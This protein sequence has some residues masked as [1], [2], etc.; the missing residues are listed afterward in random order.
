M[1]G[2]K[3]HCTLMGCY[4]TTGTFIPPFFIYQGKRI[5]QGIIDEAP[6][7]SVVGVSESGW[8][9]EDLF[10]KWLGHFNDSIPPARPALLIVDNH[11]SRF[12]L[13]IIQYCIEHQLSLLLLCPN[14]THLM[15]VGDVSIHAPFKRELRE[16]AGIFLHEHPHTSITKYHYAEIIKPAYMKAFS[17]INIQSGY[18]ATGIHPFNPDIIK[19]QLPSAPPPSPSPTIPLSEI[20]SVPGRIDNKP[21]SPRKKKRSSLPATRIL[22][23]NE[24]REAF[25]L[26]DQ[27][28]Q[29]KDEQKQ[30]KAEQKQERKRKAAV[31]KPSKRPYKKRKKEPT[32][33]E[34][35]DITPI[36]IVKEE[37]KS[38]ASIHVETEEECDE[39]D[40]EY[41]QLT[42]TTAST[43]SSSPSTRPSRKAAKW[44]RYKM[45]MDDFG[46]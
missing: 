30:Q 26:L 5:P 20:L 3:E 8:M 27:A 4:S 38:N 31:N 43:P 42:S 9:N 21:S 10:Y 12:S 25:V 33:E 16:Q 37:T 35:K 44:S 11:E 34:S 46:W 13:R 41:K 45:N 7:G 29:E 36:V 18:K 17:P 6:E 14:A 23:S 1:E 40:Q 24:M 28:T 22:T 32:L 39:E 19:C 2:T 15:Q